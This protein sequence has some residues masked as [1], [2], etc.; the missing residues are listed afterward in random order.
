MEA[1]SN[2]GLRTQSPGKHNRPATAVAAV[3]PPSDR[4]TV[5]TPSQ[6][7]ARTKTGPAFRDQR[8]TTKDRTPSAPKVRQSSPGPLDATGATPSQPAASTIA[9]PAFP[10]PRPTS[11]DG[12]LPAP[13]VRH[14]SLGPRAATGA[15]RPQ[16]AASNIAGPA[17]LDP[18]TT[19]ADRNQSA[20]KV[21]R[22]NPGPFTAEGN[23]AI[24]SAPAASGPAF[25]NSSP[26]MIPDTELPHDPRPTTTDRTPSAPKV[27]LDS[28]NPL[29]APSPGAI[30]NTQAPSAPPFRLVADEVA[31]TAPT[32]TPPNPTPARALKQAPPDGMPV[33]TWAAQALGFQADPIQTEILN[34]HTPRL[35]LCCTRQWGKSSV[36]AVKALH[37]A[38]AK[39]GAFI[40][41]AS[42][43]YKQAAELLRVIRRHA[44]KLLGARCKGDGI[45]RGAIVLPNES[46]VLAIPQ[47]PDTV[48]CFAA[49]DVIIIDEA[50]FVETEMHNALSPMLATTNGQL[51]LLSSANDT[52]GEFYKIWRGNGPDWRRFKVTA[53]E[54]PRISPEFLA[55]ERAAKGEAVFNREYMCD[56]TAIA[57]VGVPESI[58][59]DAFRGD[60]P[61]VILPKE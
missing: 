47:S 6:P 33:A 60:V 19:I 55:A 54:C 44:E 43:S 18:P 11:A 59:D 37:L 36:A 4:P 57:T 1:N 52:T 41:I 48:R 31:P 25:R 15:S 5:A 49:V 42:A 50:A 53:P 21:R 17:F 29:A 32:T 13:K 34:T 9:G 39:P 27:C 40:L 3:P 58:V 12:T 61:A 20:P 22:N 28:P 26:A 10:A 45:N 35:I 56:F 23:C 51:W 24:P 2:A 38:A 7:A 30:S 14:N 8:T 16:P 46:R